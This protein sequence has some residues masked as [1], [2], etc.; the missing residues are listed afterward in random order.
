MHLNL[1]LDFNVELGNMANNL[2]FKFTNDN[3]IVTLEL[4][5]KYTNSYSPNYS[6]EIKYS[7]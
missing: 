2:V 1:V 7:S 6:I 5:R 4:T 3:M